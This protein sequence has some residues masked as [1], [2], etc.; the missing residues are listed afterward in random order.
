MDFVIMPSTRISVGLPVVKGRSWLGA[1]LLIQVV[2]LIAYKVVDRGYLVFVPDLF[3]CGPSSDCVTPQFS[4]LIDWFLASISIMV[5]M[6]TD[7]LLFDDFVYFSY[8]YIVFIRTFLIYRV[9]L[10]VLLLPQDGV[11]ISVVVFMSL[12]HLLSIIVILRIFYVMLREIEKAK[13]SLIAIQLTFKLLLR[14]S[15]VKVLRSI[16]GETSSV[17]PPIFTTSNLSSNL[18]PICFEPLGISTN[19]SWTSVSRSRVNASVGR[20]QVHGKLNIFRTS[21]NHSFH[22]DCLM[23]WISGKPIRVELGTDPRPAPDIRRMGASCPVCASRIKLKI[24]RKTKW[25]LEYLWNRQL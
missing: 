6:I 9:L 21:C 19:R 1:L 23:R 12:A 2:Y 20:P 10:Q 7:E 15:I 24:E 13:S 22:R 16:E 14:V 4:I 25:L 5:P 3:S 18:C 17:S 8:H 11:R